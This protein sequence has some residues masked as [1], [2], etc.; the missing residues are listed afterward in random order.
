MMANSD[1]END[2]DFWAKLMNSFLDR[3]EILIFYIHLQVVSFSQK[4]YP[5]NPIR[6]C[7][8]GKNKRNLPAKEVFVH[9]YICMLNFDEAHFYWVS[10]YFRMMLSAALQ[11]GVGNYWKIESDPKKSCRQQGRKQ[12]AEKNILFIIFQL[13]YSSLEITFVYLAACSGLARLPLVI[14]FKMQMQN[15]QHSFKPL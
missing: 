5:L 2:A 14:F 1:F 15:P 3:S 11:Q 9:T 4:L 6:R 7:L 12:Q 13:Q 10:Y 8:L